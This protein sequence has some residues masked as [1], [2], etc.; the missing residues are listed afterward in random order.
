M[1]WQVKKPSRCP[2][3]LL[4]RQEAE[5]SHESRYCPCSDSPKPRV[6][7][8]PC[9]LASLHLSLFPT[10][11]RAASTRLNCSGPATPILTSYLF[12]L[13]LGD[14]FHLR[15]S[16]LQHFLLH[17]FHIPPFPNFKM[18]PSKCRLEMPMLPKMP[19]DTPVS[20]SP[21]WGTCRT[22]EP[23]VSVFRKSTAHAWLGLSDDHSLKTELKHNFLLSE[24]LS[25]HWELTLGVSFRY[26]LFWEHIWAIKWKEIPVGTQAVL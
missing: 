21:P 14:S 19:T 23:R 13:F 2:K 9:H 6:R 1:L 25:L 26:L 11:P 12:R 7:W 20:L 5:A 18:Y 24:T 22:G 3:C 4:L 16:S 8:S 17:P 10:R 15:T